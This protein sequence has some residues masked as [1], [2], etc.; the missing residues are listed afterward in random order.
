MSGWAKGNFNR[1]LVIGK[2]K[3]MRG[4]SIQLYYCCLHWSS[5]IVIEEMHMHWQMLLCTP[6]QQT[7][8]FGVGMLRSWRFMLVIT[9]Y[10]E[11]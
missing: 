8:G 9:S 5:I 7:L 10:E 1:G 3:M 11:L 6:E 4:I 2:I